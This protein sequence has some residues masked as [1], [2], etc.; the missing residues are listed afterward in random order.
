M[1]FRLMQGE[2]YLPA[3]KVFF[4]NSTESF[5]TFNLKDVPTGL[6]DVVA[7]L[8]SGL[9]TVKDGAFTVEEGLPA[10]LSVNIIAPSSVRSGNTFTVNI[11]YG[12]IGTTD[13]NVSALVVVSRHRHPIALESEDLQ[14]GETMVEFETAEPN[15]NP[16][17]LRPGSRATRTIYV[18]AT[19]SSNVSISVFAIRNYYN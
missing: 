9:V 8:P 7:E 14:L 4:S 10:E 16:D 6:Y 15:G 5:V 2:E 11:E 13:L 19:N 3:E 18:K 17:V 12:N 1:D